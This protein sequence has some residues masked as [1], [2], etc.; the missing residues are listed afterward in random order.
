VYKISVPLTLDLGQTFEILQKPTSDPNSA[1]KRIC[2]TQKKFEK[3][4]KK[5]SAGGGATTLRWLATAPA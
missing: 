1:R 2:K 3:N 5:H 4:E